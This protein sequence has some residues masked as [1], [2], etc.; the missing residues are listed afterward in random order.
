M[1]LRLGC[2]PA[3]AAESSDNIVDLQPYR[4]VETVAVPGTAA[5]VTLVNLN[6]RVNAWY[7]LSIGGGA[8]AAQ[9]YHLENPQPGAQ[10]VR[11]DPAGLRIAG[12]NADVGAERLCALWPGGAATPLVQA[13]R[14]GQPYAPL[15]GGLLYLRSALPGRYTLLESTTNFLRDHVWGGEQIISFVRDEFYRD[16][17]VEEAKPAPAAAAPAAA[18]AMLPPPAR[19]AGA[20][21]PAIALADVGI[22]LGRGVSGLLPGQWYPVQGAPGI[23]LSA[24]QP[25]AV[26]AP[27]AE[28]LRGRIGTLDAVESAALDYLVAFDLAQFDLGFALGTDHPRV[29]WSDRA[30]AQQ[31]TPGL[32]G[33][34][35]IDSAAP[36]ARTGML[37]PVQSAAV[38]ATF[39]GGFKREHGAFRYGELSQ[40]NQGSHYG[41]IEQG[42]VFS[43]LQPG[44]ATLY[45]LDDGT[46]GMKT[47]TAQD[48]AL[49]PRIR[50]ARQNGVALIEVDPASGTPQPG[51]F[52]SQW[53]PGN[54]SGSKD[55]KFRTLRAGVCLS[56]TAARQFLV[57]GY[58][59][60]ATPRAMARVFQAYGCEYA[61][62]MDMNALEHTYLAVYTHRGGRLLV[63]H[64]IE[65][66]AEVDRKGGA[67]TAPR[68]LG[69][70]DDRD[71]FYLLRR[72]GSP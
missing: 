2:T 37:N 71:F 60:T 39:T 45:V 59:S 46:V 51:R 48:D 55:E 30:P 47:W 13:R 56:R 19:L 23:F 25:R 50:H 11:L 10:T 44:L 63:Q 3:Q 7:V 62:H 21:N 72:G 33:P 5:R 68:F 66:M 32:A 36:L 20:A 35:G 12:A 61:M 27:V 16:A 9:T 43:R 42:T 4:S 14:S 69:F 28:R 22:D 24:A 64:L 52:V 41:F 15:C 1:L 57:Y 67:Q 53:G 18:E 26:D 8:A 6:P 38:A 40:V 49:L 54:W 58:F 29:G 65:G 31:R 17:F 34:D 70:P